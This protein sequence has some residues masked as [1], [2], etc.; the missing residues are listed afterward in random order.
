MRPL[1]WII[2]V[3]AILQACIN[4]DVECRC[5]DCLPA[6]IEENK[7][8]SSKKTEHFDSESDLRINLTLDTTYLQNI[9]SN[10][11][12]KHSAFP[13]CINDVGHE[14]YPHILNKLDYFLID[15]WSLSNEV[16]IHLV[17]GEIPKDT[18][19]TAIYYYRALYLVSYNE[20]GEH[21]DTKVVG[22]RMITE[23][24]GGIYESV[25]TEINDNILNVSTHS[26][27]YSSSGR[28]YSQW[29]DTEYVIR[30]DGLIKERTA[31]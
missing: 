14:G 19:Q 2:L 8:L 30:K 29:T 3:V 4:K 10:T 24:N 15:E 1:L 6:L 5:P 26:H 9:Q 7:N 12:Q 25:L 21:I 22:K 27:W 20:Y 16:I 11:L 17:Y 31:F 28:Y 13:G 18:L 23:N